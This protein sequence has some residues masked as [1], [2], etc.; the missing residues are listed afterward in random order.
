MYFVQHIT[1]IYTF[2][3]IL[4]VFAFLTGALDEISDLKVKLVVI[5]FFIR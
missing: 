1:F 5:K 2:R 3:K 4:P